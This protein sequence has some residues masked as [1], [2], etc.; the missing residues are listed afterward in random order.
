VTA[1][2]RIC[3]IRGLEK[4][5][6]KV[7]PSKSIFLQHRYRYTSE[8]KSGAVE[9]SSLVQGSR[10]NRKVH[11]CNASDAHDGSLVRVI[12]ICKLWMKKL[13]DERRSW[14]SGEE[15]V[16]ESPP[17]LADTAAWGRSRSYNKCHSDLRIKIHT[18]NT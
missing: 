11:V 7:L 3:G 4:W 8:P 15:G 5:G 13:L 6:N 10:R 1:E 16:L 2:R 18:P 9:C 17:T 12:E 14:G